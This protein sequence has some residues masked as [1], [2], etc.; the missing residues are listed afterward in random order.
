A[1]ARGDADARVAAVLAAAGPSGL[2][3]QELAGRSALAAKPLAAALERLGAKGG[4]VLFDRERR[5][6]VSGEVARALS[7]RLVDAV[8]AFHAAHPLAPGVP[9]EE[10][11][12]RLPRAAEV[13]L[14]ARL[15]AALVEKGALVAEGDHVRDPKHRAASGAAAGAL[16]EKVASA[17]ARGGVTPPWL[18]ELPG[19]LSADADDVTAVLKLLAAEGRAVRVSAELWFDAAAVGGLREKLVA[20]LRARKEITTQ[21]FKDLVGATRKHVIPLAEYFDREKVTLRVGD[22]RLLRGDGR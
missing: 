3:G 5:A 20:H 2:A 22:R 11:R 4:A 1:L 8:R 17:L 12:G 18:A 7:A 15:L 13:R 6:Y 14:F 21:E 16:K 19:L 10:L 9:R